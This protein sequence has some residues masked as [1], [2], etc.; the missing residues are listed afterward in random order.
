MNPVLLKSLIRNA[1]FALCVLTAFPLGVMAQPSPEP[2]QKRLLNGLRIKLWARPSDQDVLLK[3]R[4]HSGAAFDLAGKAGTMALLGDI[5]F[6]DPTTREY[7]AEEMQGRLN[8]TTDYDSITITLQGRA[9]EFEQIIEILRTALVATQLTPEN[10]AKAREGRIKVIRESSVS[11]AMLADRAIAARLFGDFPYGRPYMGTIESLERVERGD[12][13]L[14]RDR[15]LN[16]NNSS[17]VIIGGVQ[18]NRAMRALRQLLGPW[19]KGDQLVPATFR[20]PTAPDSRT[21]ILNAPA[22]QSVEVRL[23]VRGFAREDP[24]WAAATMLASVTLQRWE[25]LLPELARGPVFV[26]HEAFALPGRFVMGTTIDGLLAGKTLATGQEAIRSFAS[27]PVTS[28]ELEQAK[29]EMMA[30][31]NK[32]LAKPEGVADAWLDVDTYG[33]PAIAEQIRSLSAVSQNDLQRAAERLFRDGA[34]ASVVVG[35]SE[36]VKT[37]IERYGKVELMGEI[38]PKTETKLDSKPT[39]SQTKPAVKP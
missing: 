9:R 24:D 21:L 36:L 22:D 2:E 4:V 10:V 39:K 14:A 37:Q 30:L 23:A 35:N 31:L 34:Y 15:F 12:L 3:L 28:S 38:D 5:L 6:P 13:M 19:R 1:L 27:S 17:L 33:L 32:E 8:V 26:R 29:G 25:K 18:P 20:Q 7:F 11:P 16:S